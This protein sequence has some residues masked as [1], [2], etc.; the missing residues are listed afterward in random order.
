MNC[1]KNCGRIV[2][3]RGKRFCQICFDKILRCIICNKCMYDANYNICIKCNKITQ[4]KY[5]EC[6]IE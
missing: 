2:R 5:Q 6:L 1:R 4:N 3:A